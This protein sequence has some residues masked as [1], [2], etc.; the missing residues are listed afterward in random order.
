M[1]WPRASA[2]IIAPP[3]KASAGSK[4]AAV[5]RP[6]GSAVATSPLRC[7]IW[8][9][10][11]R[12]ASLSRSAGMPSRG[13]AADKAGRRDH[14]DRRHRLGQRREIAVDQLQLL[15]RRHLRD[16]RRGAVRR[17]A[18]LP[19]RAQPRPP[20]HR[21][22]TA[23]AVARPAYRCEVDDV[24]HGHPFACRQKFSRTRP[25]KVRGG[26]KFDRNTGG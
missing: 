4:V 15:R 24:G 2:P 9:A 19:C 23:A 25:P 18:I 26:C 12:L 8:L 13:D 21:A 17:A 20:E 10:T 7:S 1:S 16:Q 3:A 5:A 6:A 22:A 11:P 14:C